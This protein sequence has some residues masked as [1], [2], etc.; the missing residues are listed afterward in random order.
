MPWPRKVSLDS[1]PR[2]RARRRTYNIMLQAF[3]DTRFL[4]RSRRC[5]LENLTGRRVCCYLF[6]SRL[7]LLFGQLLL[8]SLVDLV[9]GALGVESPLDQGEMATSIKPKLGTSWARRQRGRDLGLRKGRRG[10]PAK[11]SSGAANHYY[12]LEGSSFELYGSHRKYEYQ[13]LGEQV[14]RLERKLGVIFQYCPRHSKSVM[15]YA[16]A[17]QRQFP[18]FPFPRRSSRWSLSSCGLFLPVT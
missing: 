5:G 4:A 14:S 12:G 2:N 6:W 9:V 15:D 17:V 13:W 8:G 10:L 16:G 1:D 7:E 3:I 11:Q 18:D